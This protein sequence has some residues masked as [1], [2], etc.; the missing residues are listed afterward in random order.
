ME[1]IGLPGKVRGMRVQTFH[2]WIAACLHVCFLTVIASP[3]SAEALTLSFPLQC[4]LHETC[5]IQNYVDTD[6]SP[7]RQDYRCGEATYDGHKGTDFRVVSVTDAKQGVPVIAAAAGRV[8]AIRDGM[9]DRLVDK[10]FDALQGKECGNGVVIDHG[11]GW[12]TQYCHMRR[13]SIR[14]RQGQ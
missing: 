11:Q 13:G 9:E 8:K 4:T 6:P 2:L 3:A 14:V 5:F 7:E 10:D 12:E 1:A